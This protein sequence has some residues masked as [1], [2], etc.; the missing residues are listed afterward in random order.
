MHLLRRTSAATAVSG[1][2]LPSRPARMVCHKVAAVQE[3]PTQSPSPAGGEESGVLAASSASPS[4]PP[5]ADA[6]ALRLESLDA[7][8][9]ELLK[10]MLFVDE[11]EQERDLGEMVDYAEFSAAAGEDADEELQE[12]VEKMMEQSAVDLRMGDRVMGTVYE[13]DEDGAYVEVGAKTAGFVPLSERSLAKLKSASTHT[14]FFF[15]S[16]GELTP[17]PLSLPIA[18][19]ARTSRR[20]DRP[21][22]RARHT[23]P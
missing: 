23:V 16:V 7:A 1:R 10:W 2:R 18:R 15:L 4:A 6:A 21:M 9:E 14:H 5:A 3:Q 8:Q 17:L 13:V 20:W 19:A 12:Q 22:R 11:D